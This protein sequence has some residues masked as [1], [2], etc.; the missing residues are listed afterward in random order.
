MKLDLTWRIQAEAAYILINDATVRQT[1]KVF[2]VSKSTVSRDI[3]NKLEH[4]NGEL[5]K[6]TKQILRR[7]RG[8]K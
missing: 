6:E 1:A 4:V 3:C 8:F 7:H 5:Y 2:R